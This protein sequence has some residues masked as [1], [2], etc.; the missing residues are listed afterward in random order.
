MFGS[1]QT[2]R[3]CP[4]ECE[5]CA[6][7]SFNGHTY[8]QRPIED[9]LDELEKIP[10]KKFFF[11]DDNIIGYSKSA[12]VRALGLFKGIIERG[13][14]KEWFCQASLNFADDEEILKYAAKSGCR[15]VVLGL[16]AENVKSLKDANKKLNL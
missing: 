9:V 12:S 2:A 10:Q 5:F 7:N 8:R 1:I 11:V 6:V 14:K 3:G 13:I 15:M 4:M 16:E